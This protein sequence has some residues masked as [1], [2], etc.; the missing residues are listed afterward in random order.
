MSKANT[1]S[2]AAEPRPYYLPPGVDL[3]ALPKPMR[4]AFEAIVQ[5]TYAELVLA[6]PT[7]LERA[8]GVSLHFLLCLEVLEQFELGH[9]LNFT[10]ASAGDDQAERDRAI[11]KHLKLVSAKQHAANFLARLQNLRTKLRISPYDPL[12]DGGLGK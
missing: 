3:A 12:R 10:G 2:A 8:V 5:P 1:K 4:L 11:A 6:A 7:S 9:Q